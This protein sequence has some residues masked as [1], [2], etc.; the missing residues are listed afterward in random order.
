MRARWALMLLGLLLAIC[1]VTNAAAGEDAPFYAVINKKPFSV[2]LIDPEKLQIASNIPLEAS[3]ALATWGADYKSVYVML[4]EKGTGFFDLNQQ[5]RLSVIDIATRALVKTIKIGWNPQQPFVSPDRRYL[6]YYCKGRSGSKKAEAENAAIWLVDTT[7]HELVNI[8]RS[9]RSVPQMPYGDNAITG[10]GACTK[11]LDFTLFFSQMQREP[12]KPDDPK[13]SLFLFARG[14]SQPLAT[15]EFN[16]TIKQLAYSPD[17]KWL[18]LLDGGQASDKP[19]KNRDGKVYVVEVSSGKIIKEISV[20][21]VPRRLEID[22]KNNV[23]LLLAQKGPKDEQGLLFHIRGTEISEPTPAGMSPLFTRQLEGL[24]GRVLVSETELNQLSESGAIAGSPVQINKSKGG[25]QSGPFLDGIPGEMIYSTA[26]HRLIASAVTSAGASTGNLAV[27]DIDKKR[28]LNRISTGHIAG[29]ILKGLAMAA[30]TGMVNGYNAAT[31]S[32][33]YAPSPNQITESTRGGN[34]LELWPD[35]IGS[36]VYALNSSTHEA[37]VIQLSDGSVS[38]VLKL[39]K[40]S[41]QILSSPDGKTLLTGHVFEYK[42]A[43]P[44][45]VAL[46]DTQSG[47]LREIPVPGGNMQSIALDENRHRALVFSRNNLMII[48]YA[49]GHVLGTISQFDNQLLS[50]TPLAQ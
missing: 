9:N 32:Y 42:V 12:K 34:H 33:L 29:Q 22:E 8:Y 5:G 4:E 49:D 47:N 45:S 46:I 3:P 38:K 27:I 24:P 48:D 7:T 30:G 35:P 50:A 10:F 21:S 14:Q 40:G 6:A 36:Q 25:S 28:L 15:L 19:E 26:A 37:H 16:H 43:E 31:G 17:Q 18:Y 41:N 11:N 20:G 1:F 39:P 2:V 13:P 23:V 44:D